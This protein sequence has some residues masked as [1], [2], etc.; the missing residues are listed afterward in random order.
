M[1]ENFS[2]SF[3]LPMFNESANIE[4]AIGVLKSLAEDLTDDYEIIAVDDASTDAS[5]QIVRGIAEYDK[6]VRLFCLEK[7]TKF[8]GAFAKGF[9]E[10]EKDVILYMDSDL[11]VSAEDVKKSLPLVREADIV[12]GYSKINKGETFL[13]KI[14]SGVY[15]SIVQ[16]MFGLNVR[17]INSGY[18]IVRKSLVEDLEFLSHSPFADVELFLHAK[19]KNATVKQFPLIF[20]ERIGGKSYIARPAV[21]LATFLDMVKV[22]LSINRK[23]S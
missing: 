4:A 14:I 11:P 5:A 19:R 7:N 15:N 18:K 13:R 16:M 12:S 23:N 21:M 20:K 8:G 3:V 17:D 1:K 6:T 9:K 10:A 2:I 22:R